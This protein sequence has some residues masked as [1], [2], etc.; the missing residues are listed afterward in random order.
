[1]GIFRWT[2][3]YKELGNGKRLLPLHPLAQT[4]SC[5]C[6]ECFICV[7]LFFHIFAILGKNFPSFEPLHRRR[8]PEFHSFSFTCFKFPCFSCSKSDTKHQNVQMQMSSMSWCAVMWDA[9]NE[10]KKLVPYYCTC[11]LFRSLILTVWWAM[12]PCSTDM[13]LQNLTTHLILWILI[14]I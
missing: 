3:C 6:S 7:W 8:A 10:E 4:S 2:P 14:L 12:L 1:M 11:L 13:V 9:C 5:C